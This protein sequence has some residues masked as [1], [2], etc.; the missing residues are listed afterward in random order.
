[1]LSTIRRVLLGVMDRLVRSLTLRSGE[2]RRHNASYGAGFCKGRNSLI[3]DISGLFLTLL[4]RSLPQ[5]AQD[6]LGRQVP[7]PSRLGDPDESAQLFENMVAN[8]C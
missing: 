7:F 2:Y 5:G 1:M 8:R 3:D 4:L 6:F